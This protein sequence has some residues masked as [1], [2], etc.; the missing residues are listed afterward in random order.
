M[1]ALFVLSPLLN[2]ELEDI[3]EWV[4]PRLA[5]VEEA[6]DTLGGLTFVLAEIG[7]MLGSLDLIA[8]ILTMFFLATYGA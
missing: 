4:D 3:A 2:A 1:R 5:E 7:I 8:P 6:V